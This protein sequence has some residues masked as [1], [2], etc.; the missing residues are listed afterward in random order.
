[1]RVIK[2]FLHPKTV[3]AL[4]KYARDT[5]LMR[6]SITGWHKD[7]VGLLGPVMQWDL[8]GDFAAAIK[9]EIIDAHDMEPYHDYNWAISVHM[10]P[11]LSYIPWH[12][13]Q[14]H[15]VNITVYLNATWRADDQGYFIYDDEGVLKAIV[16][17]NNLGLIYKTPLLHTVSLTNVRAEVRESLQIFINRATALPKPYPHTPPVPNAH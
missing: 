11:R 4:R 13:D 16:P 1:M 12:N 6:C 14:H 15:E 2:N 3:E 9:G 8:D 10:M 5:R 7:V 17:Q